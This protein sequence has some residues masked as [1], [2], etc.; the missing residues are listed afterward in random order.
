[1]R[2]ISVA[3]AP[4]GKQDFLD[5][6]APCHG[7]DGKGHGEAAYL[8]PNDKPPDLTMLSRDN[9]GAFPTRIVYK[10]IDGRDGIPPHKRFNMPFWGT[11]FQPG[12]KEFTKAGD[13]QARARIMRIVNYIKTIQQK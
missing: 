3:G 4:S 11:E 8:V 10:S 1:L 12:G 13:A 5:N 7:A 9:G 6:C 2:G